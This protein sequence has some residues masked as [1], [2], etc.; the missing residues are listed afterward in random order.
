MLSIGRKT[1]TSAQGEKDFFQQ[2]LAAAMWVAFG[3][4]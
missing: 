2:F 4:V 1:K 3:T